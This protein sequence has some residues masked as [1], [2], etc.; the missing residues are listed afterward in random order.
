MDND[1]HPRE[2]R[3]GSLVINEFGLIHYKGNVVSFFA[4]EKD[5]QT[6]QA[7]WQREFTKEVLPPLPAKFFVLVIAGKKQYFLDIEDGS[8]FC[9]QPLKEY[10]K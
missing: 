2:S 1:P 6:K 10:A 5:Y 9:E 4:D 3:E 7:R 8:I